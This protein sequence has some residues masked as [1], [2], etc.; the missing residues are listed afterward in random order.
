[1]KPDSIVQRARQLPYEPLVTTFTFRCPKQM[2]A[3]IKTF[4]MT[5]GLDSSAVL[6]ALINEAAELHGIKLRA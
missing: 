5:H 6:R 1:M 4:A 3:G 2:S